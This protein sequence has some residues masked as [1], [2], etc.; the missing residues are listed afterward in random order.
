[1]NLPTN[2]TFK[3][4]FFEQRV[5]DA[6]KEAHRI[7]NLERNPRLAGDVNHDYADKAK[8]MDLT[9]T[10]TLRFHAC[11]SNEF[12]KEEVMD[13]PVATALQTTMETTTT[14]SFPGNTK[15]STV[16]EVLNREQFSLPNHQEYTPIE[17]PLT[18]LL[19][20]IDIE[21]S[22]GHFTIDTQDKDRKTPRRNKQ[23]EEA[24]AF[25]V[26]L[27]AWMG[28]V[29]RHVTRRYSSDIRDKLHPV[30][31]LP[32]RPLMEEVDGDESDRSKI[33]HA[34]SGNDMT[35]LLNEHVQSLNKAG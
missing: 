14:G 16:E 31:F 12:I 27:S 23:V 5:S 20:Q 4:V 15:K 18:W 1:M 8:K 25:H 35:L 19:N 33:T 28:A 3:D 29:Y 2:R 21:S 10:T 9:K 24:L 7:L 13:V 11:D 26:E 6:L 34:L 30:L 22:K 17:V 32:I